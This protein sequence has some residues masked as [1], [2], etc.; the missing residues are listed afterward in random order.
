LQLDSANNLRRHPLNPDR[1]LFQH[2]G[3]QGFPP[4]LQVGFAGM[5][6]PGELLPSFWEFVSLEAEIPV[7]KL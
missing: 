1:E 6:G 3:S 2:F 5:S 7:F 4:L